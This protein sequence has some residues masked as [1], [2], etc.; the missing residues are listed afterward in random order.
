MGT[1]LWVVGQFRPDSEIW[2]L[3]GIFDDEVKAVDACIN[4]NYFVAPVELNVVF[5]DEASE[6]PGMYY[7]LMKVEIGVEDT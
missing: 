5:P 7:P 6:W 4:E 3:Q 1:K 2:E